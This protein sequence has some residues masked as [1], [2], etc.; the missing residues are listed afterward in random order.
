M[1]NVF[2][3]LT[4]MATGWKWPVGHFKNYYLDSEVPI[5]SQHFSIAQ[6]SSSD[7]MMELTQL[8]PPQENFHTLLSSTEPLR[9]YQHSI[10]MHVRLHPCFRATYVGV[11]WV[12]VRPLE[13]NAFNVSVSCVQTAELRACELDVTRSVDE[14]VPGVWLLKVGN[15]RFMSV[16]WRLWY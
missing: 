9:F 12:I 7:I 3:I 13:P 14:G 4:H 11:P 5:L 15:L 8:Q 16:V 1:Y 6:C 2:P 10:K